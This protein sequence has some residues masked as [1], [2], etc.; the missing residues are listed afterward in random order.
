[1]FRNR[2]EESST[3]ERDILNALADDGPLHVLELAERVTGHPIT[4]DQTCAQ[5]HNDGH[6]Y[7]V[8]GGRYRLTET[9]R[10]QLTADL[11]QPTRDEN[12]V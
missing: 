11:A 2:V 5:L 6:I 8:G 7:P 9:G 12:T 3:M 10:D 1:M 4:V